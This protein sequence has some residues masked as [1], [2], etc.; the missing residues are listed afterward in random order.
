MVQQGGVV[1]QVDERSRLK[2]HAGVPL[3]STI[4]GLLS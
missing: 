1:Y 4:L 3:P 2:G